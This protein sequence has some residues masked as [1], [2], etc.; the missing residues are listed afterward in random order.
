M[1]LTLAV[2]VLAGSLAL[3]S[4]AVA[5]YAAKGAQVHRRSG[6]LF[7]VAML[8]MCTLGAALAAGQPWAEVNIPAALMTA[9]LVITSLTTVRPAAV[10][11]RWL[12]VGLLIVAAV[13]SAMTLTFGLE[14]VGSGGRRNGIPAFPF[15]LFGTV[16]LIGSLG[17]VRMLRSGPLRGAAR[18]TRHLWRMSFALFI[19]AMSFFFGQMDVIPQPVRKPALLALPVLA[20]LATMLYWLWKVRVR[21]SF[22]GIV[23]ATAPA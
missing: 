20:V 21:R 6:L 23:T 10:G 1:T 9:Y 3:V 22:R 13:V 16:G 7:V 11:S 17:D 15:F 14:A 18:L 2:H 4:G 8:T 5:L 12:D 19:A